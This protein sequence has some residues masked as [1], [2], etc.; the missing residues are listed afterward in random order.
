[1]KRT[2][3]IAAVLLSLALQ[4]PVRAAETKMDRI[5]TVTNIAGLVAFWESFVKHEPNGAHRFTTHVLEGAKNDFP[6][7]A[8]KYNEDYWG[9]RQS[10]INAV[11]IEEKIEAVAVSIRN[12]TELVFRAERT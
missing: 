11:E 3:R 4:I 9:E 2:G 12:V 7:D 10:D 8:G 6:L 1:M 5:A